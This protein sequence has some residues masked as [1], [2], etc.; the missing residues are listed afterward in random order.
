MAYSFP[1][2]ITSAGLQ[3]QSLASLQS[4]LLA[5]V[6]ATNPGYTA[7][8]PG[9]LIEDVSSTDVAAISLCDQAKVDLVNSLTPYG[10]NL[11]L[12]QQLGAI[13]GVAQNV[14][15]NTSVYVV[16][17]GPPGFV[18]AQ[19][20]VVG[21]G[22]YEYIVQDG[23]I[24]GTDGESVGLYAVATVTGSWAVPINT[25]TQL[26]TSI[27]TIYSVT[28]SNPAAGLPGFATG[29]TEE[30]YRSRVLMAGAAPSQGMATQLKTLLGEVSG[31]QTQLISVLQQSGGG[32]E[33][34]CG[35]GDPY[36]VAYAIYT[37]LFD[38]ST[39]V[40][41]QLAVSGITNAANGV[42]TTN[43]A[44]GLLTGAQI[45]LTGIVGMAALNGVLLTITVLT[46]FTFD[47]NVNTSGYGAY[48]SGGAIS[49]NP[50]NVTVS[51]LDFP[52]TYQVT[53]VNPPQEVVTMT[54]DWHSISPNYANPATIAGLAQTSIQAYVNSITVGQPMNLLQL[55][56][57]FTSSLPTSIPESSISILTFAVYI[58]GVLVAPV[59]NLI[60]SDPESYF[61]V[62]LTGITVNAI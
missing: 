59:N 44:H 46:A 5:N 39:L 22:T 9:S 47:T 62:T 60:S 18:I 16:F 14:P 58:N 4:Q 32:W 49:P 3:P 31:V 10:A 43:L 51:I 1:I 26:I 55:N 13:Y 25:V 38:I 27:P 2:V 19:G 54:V 61:Y 20:F 30:S 29:E 45:T 36:Q 7:N 42:V 6:A 28:V 52:D 40:G 17:I 8:L 11:V 57:A 50:R 12:L 53:F 33:V 23:G 34:I 24:I 56:D 21:D 15:T 41:S 37:A 35:G 48:V